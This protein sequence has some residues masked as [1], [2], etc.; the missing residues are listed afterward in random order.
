MSDDKRRPILFKG[1]VYSHPIEKPSG[2]GEKEFKVSYEQARVQLLT[3]IQKTKAQISQLPQTSKLPN[4]TVLCIR[5][6]S[7]F[8]AKTWYPNSLFDNS[9]S[10]RNGLKE[11]GSRIWT[12]ESDEEVQNKSRGKLLFVRATEQGLL[13]FE[14]K[15]NQEEYLLTK[16]FISDIRK[17]SSLDLLSPTEQILGINEDWD[18]GRLEAVLHPFALDKN[19]A[20]SHF[21]NV[22]KED[23]INTDQIRYKQ[24]GDGVTFVSFIGD[25]QTLKTLAGY[26]PLRTVHPLLMRNIPEFTRSHSSSDCPQPPIFSKKSSI[27]VGVLDGGITGSNPYLD[28]YI[29]IEDSVSGTMEPAFT[30]HGRHVCGTVLYGPLNKYTSTDQLPEPPISVKSFRVISPDNSGDPDLYEVI[31]AIEEIVPKNKNIS[32]YN[33]SLGP[34][35][36]ILDDSIS[37]FTFACDSLSNEHNVLFCVAVGN[38]GEMDGYNRI[39]S[40][41]DMVNGLAIGAYTKIDGTLTKAPYSCIG[42]GREGNKMK[43]DLLAFGGCSNSPIH[44]LGLKSGERSWDAGT[45]FASP[46]A[47]RIAAQLI[48]ESN[49][50]IDPLISRGLM[51]HSVIDKKDIKHTNE[52]GHGFLTEDISKIITCPDK[53]YTLIYRG[54]LMPGKYAE[55]SIPWINDITQ[56][57]VS[58][59]WT[60]AILT[61]VNHQSP[62]DYTSTSI[63]AMFYPNKNKYSLVKKEA[64]KKSKFKKIDIVTNEAEYHKLLSE[65]WVKPKFPAGDYSTNPF[66]TEEELKADLKW[67]SIDT[68]IISKKTSSIADPVFHL[69]ALGR[70]NNQPKVKFALILTVEA[71]KAEI[72]LYSKI[73]NQYSALTPL[74]INLNIPIQISSGNTSN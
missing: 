42:P 62:D 61:N 51:I 53:S 14:K 39:Q 30:D 71:P 7:E 57:K 70:G 54:E 49:Q 46:I 6:R 29:E 44:L 17:V 4:E 50:F 60:V 24:Y 18:G 12:K 32:V 37:R 13:D 41:S 56:G 23:K 1:E 36:P 10:S 38:D 43:P 48:G 65:G 15:L 21:F 73:I 64:G 11:I 31:D 26:N 67:D 20:L 16:A 74:N 68:R 55:F 3:N 8:S 19:L 22:L 66:Q 69:H 28:N 58:F 2:G 47:A 34:T 52:L 45:S 33:L 40:P 25:R 59:H 63:H 5:L 35:G 72:D 9:N 27:V